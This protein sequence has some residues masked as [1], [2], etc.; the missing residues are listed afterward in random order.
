MNDDALQPAATLTIVAISCRRYYLCSNNEDGVSLFLY[1]KEEFQT[2]LRSSPA[3]GKSA[4]P[5]L[6]H[7]V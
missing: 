1:I 7:A 4:W 5:T 6:T 3:F 2:L